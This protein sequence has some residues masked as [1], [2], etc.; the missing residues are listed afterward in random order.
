MKGLNKLKQP[1]QEQ[2]TV[3]PV[4]APE[5]VS[6]YTLERLKD[7]CL[8]PYKN[9]YHE[10]SKESNGWANISEPK[11]AVYKSAN[12]VITAATTVEEMGPIMQ[13]LVDA[14]V[15]AE[16]TNLL[17]GFTSIF[18]SSTGLLVQKAQE[19]KNI[20]EENKVKVQSSEHDSINKPG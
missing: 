18:S 10:K 3:D 15:A 8:E 14:A 5:S 2:N 6:E 17:K 20:F 4:Q 16:K 12:E 1:G 13:R 11:K 9:Y 7:D 19:A